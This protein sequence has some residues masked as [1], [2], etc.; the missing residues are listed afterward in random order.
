MKP[1]NE[2]VINRRIFFE[3]AGAGIAGY[4]LSPMDLGAQIAPTTS[5]PAVLMGT[6]KN[7]VFVLLPG[8]PSHTDTFDLKV[9]SW[10]PANFVPT[11]LNGFDFPSG[12]LPSFDLAV[13][14]DRSPAKLPVERAGAF[15]CCKRGIKLRGIRPV[16]VR[17]SLLI[18]DLLL[19]WRLI[20]HADPDR[21]C[22]GSSR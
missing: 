14:Q 5:Q 21:F 17:A 7:V 22:P 13:R 6:A 10:T 18:L 2:Q 11:S 3:I 12:L 8:A 9:G 4:F 16:Q 19:Q 20:P 15:T 1:L